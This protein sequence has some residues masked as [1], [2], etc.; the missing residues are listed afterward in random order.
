M[1]NDGYKLVDGS[2]VAIIGGGPAGTSCAI[3]L[4]KEAKRKN[5]KVRVI[6]FESKDFNIHYNQCVGVL[7][8]PIEEI[9]ENTL[10]IPFPSELIKREIKGYRIHTD[11]GNTFGITRGEGTYATRRILFDRFMLEKAKE[12]GAEVINSRVTGI[13]FYNGDEVRVYS[14]GK[15]LRVDAVVGAFGLDE[16]AA[17]VVE[18]ASEKTFCYRRPGRA[19]DT[20]ITKLHVNKS[21]IENNLDSEIHAFLL[22][23]LK[24]IEFGA[25]T[26]KGDHIIIN[27]AGRN[28]T[29]MEM[30]L[31]LSCPAVKSVLGDIDLS[32]LDY[33]KGRY[34]IK[35]ARGI[36]GDRFVAVGD[37][38]GWIRPYKG[39]GINVAI[40]T[41]AKAGEAMINYGISRK[42][43]VHYID[44]F[45]T[46]EGDYYYGKVFR[47]LLLFALKTGFIDEVVKIAR[48][49]P[50]LEEGVYMAVSGE[51]KYSEILKEIFAIKEFSKLAGTFVNFFLKKLF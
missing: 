33:F 10:G 39:K 11:S 50:G 1:L 8:P 22:N 51:G 31:F 34:P 12:F 4:L 2:Q 7:S 13:E 18:K 47:T 14:E 48:T 41:G 19:L 17:D 5:L 37:A 43:L 21:V 32:G 24:G 42:D 16:G 6:I 15:F 27:I 36:I 25:I 29:S 35:P 28:V 30:D 40:E 46:L 20:I 38:T 26:P 3:K 44:R 45:K 23:N 49:S 9:F